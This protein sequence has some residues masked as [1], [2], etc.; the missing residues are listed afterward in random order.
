MPK[1]RTA[2]ISAYNKEK[3]GDIAKKLADRNIE[4]WASSGTAAFLREQNIPVTS[5]DGLVGFSQLLGGRVK[6]LHPAIFSGILARDTQQDFAQLRQRDYPVFDMVFVDLY[7]FLENMS[8]PEGELVELIDIGGVALLRAAAKNY[9]RV[10]VAYSPEQAQ[11]IIDSMDD[12][13]NV[14][15]ELTRQLAAE[16]FY[17]TSVYDSAIATYLHG[18]EGFPEYLSFGGRNAF[19]LRYGENPHQSGAVYAALP[20]RGLLSAEIL[21]GKQLS[22]NNLLDI[23]A[24]L[25]GVVEFEE[26]AC[27]IVKHLSPCGIATDEDIHAAYEKSLASDPLSAFGGIVA[28]NRPVDSALAERLTRHFFECVAAPDFVENSL[29]ILRRKKNLRILKVPELSGGEKI[30][31][32]GIWGGFVAQETNPPGAMAQK[33]EV[34]SRR[35]PTDYE[36][37]QMCFAMRAAKLVKSNAIVIAKDNATV[38]IGGGLPSRV[39][40][41]IVAVR[42]AGDRAKGAVAASDAFLPFPDTL[43]VLAQS[44]VTAL[45]QPGGSRNDELVIRAA[46]ELG[47]AMVFTGMRHF[48][49]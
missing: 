17:F 21:G 29:E 41:A 25:A 22:Y 18:G 44:G 23:D 26:P 4:I 3:I 46:N 10:A 36:E 40:A 32:R 8:L 38:G 6:T 35:K 7:P 19:P 28:F 15:T 16:T 39:D 27:T 43:Y 9:A 45:V 30:A 31:V 14:P 48:R 33:W 13:N 20:P 5:I 49:H 11:K 12:E 24:A 37:M 42:K 2:L 47:I 1:I 34:V